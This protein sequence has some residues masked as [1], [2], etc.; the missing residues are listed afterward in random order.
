MLNAERVAVFSHDYPIGGSPTIKGIVAYL[1]D[2]SGSL[3]L[4]VDE[5][6]QSRTIKLPAN[7]H[8]QFVVPR[9]YYAIV[10]ALHRGLVLIRVPGRLRSFYIVMY[11]AL[12]KFLAYLTLRRSIHQYDL[13]FCIEAHSLFILKRAGY[14]L[15]KVIFFSL[16]S[17]Q[18]LREYD[19]DKSSRYISDCLMRVTQSKER[20]IGLSR[21]LGR[22][23]QYE[24]LPVSRI[25]VNVVE[26][27]SSAHATTALIF[28]GLFADWS[29]L[30]EFVGAYSSIKPD[31]RRSLTIQGYPV[32]KD[33]EYY[34]SILS[35]VNYCPSILFD[36]KFYDDDEHMMLLS[37]HD[38]GLALYK[39]YEGNA[40]W[41]KNE[42]I[43]CSGKLATYLWARL[44]IITNIRTPLTMKPPFLYIEQITPQA[45]LECVLRFED[46][47]LRYRNA[48]Y[49]L[50]RKQYD[51]FEHMRKIDSKLSRVLK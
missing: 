39:E 3:D 41:V 16:E 1:A 23:L 38:I 18:I 27:G 2:H 12:A 10:G 45:I 13:V 22:D 25:P 37:K 20:G 14:P 19:K 44:A 46:S 40:N 11:R 43:Y 15:S 29:H 36:Q 7:L 26:N 9:L 51:I 5:L 32:R 48:A 33:D 31:D 42:F 50:A 34:R 24:Y 17:D 30:N 21:Y 35:A 8:T 4:L 6:D 28:S 49:E 47:P